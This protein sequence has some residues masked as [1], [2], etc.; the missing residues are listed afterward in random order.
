MSST[1]S[2]VAYPK[3]R[4]TYS[5]FRKVNGLVL[6]AGFGPHDP[7][8]GQVRGNTI[9]VQ[10][11]A[12]LSNIAA[13][14]S[15]AELTLADVVKATVHLHN[16]ERD[17]AGFEATYHELFSPPYPVRTTVGSL[18]P[19]FLVEIDVIA[20]TGKPELRRLEQ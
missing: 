20:G 19:G 7:V 8:S 12:A 17:Y 1:T 10:T 14:L 6:T 15:A 4:A 3:P 18:L 2:S 16:L 9:E 5:A 13:V 11:A